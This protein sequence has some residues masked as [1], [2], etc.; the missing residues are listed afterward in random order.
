M[1]AFFTGIFKLDR[2]A[3]VISFIRL[4]EKTMGDVI[5]SIIGVLM[6]FQENSKVLILF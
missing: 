6:S 3:L 2:F 5:F 4:F 1:L